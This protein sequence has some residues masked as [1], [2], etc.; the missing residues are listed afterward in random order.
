MTARTRILRDIALAIER[1]LLTAQ[2]HQEAHEQLDQ[3]IA[4]SLP[5]IREMGAA[6]VVA[7]V[8]ITPEGRWQYE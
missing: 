5:D 7:R 1:G 2:D 3:Q 6:P 4:D 8:D